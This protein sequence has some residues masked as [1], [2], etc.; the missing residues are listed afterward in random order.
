MVDT[1]WIELQNQNIDNLQNRSDTIDCKTGEVK[2]SVG[3]SDCIKIK[4]FCEKTIIECS[5][6][7]LLKGN[8]IYSLNFHEVL[9][10]IKLIEQ[11]L[12][13]SVSNGI[14]RRLDCELTIEALHTPSNYFRYFGNS[15]YYIRKELNYT[16]LY[17][18]N[19]SRVINIYDKIIEIRDKKEIVPNEFKGLN[20]LRFECRYK[21]R[22]LKRL[23]KQNS[24]EVLRIKD[25]IHPKTYQNISNVVF[26]EYEAID[27]LNEPI[28]LN[29]NDSV[30]SKADLMKNLANI[31]I[32]YLGGVNK[33]Q[34]M[35]D[36]SR[37][38]NKNVRNEYFSRRKKD[39]INIASTSNMKL[40][41]NLIDEINQKVRKKYHSIS[42]IKN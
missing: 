7:K 3:Y 11:K 14:I 18:S 8:N 30:K 40:T 32:N 13:I 5:L 34:E 17:Y 1:I 28:I 6:P 15:K 37:P 21:N 38:F 25:L 39:I 35:I 22:Y 36:S 33:V 41:K 2:Y 27:K 12:G 42:Q 9:N 4:K 31:A 19:K 23:A 20:L 24:K 29:F 16:S 10:A 26:N